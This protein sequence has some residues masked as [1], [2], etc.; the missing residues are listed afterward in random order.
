MRFGGVTIWRSGRDLSRPP[1]P[2]LVDQIVG[3]GD[4][5][6]DLCGLALGLGDAF[7]LPVGDGDGE[8]DGDAI[9]R[10]GMTVNVGIGDWGA[11]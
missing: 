5:V 11:A 3:L 6:G 7:A 10:V 4:G 2:Y 1:R 8:A 9:G